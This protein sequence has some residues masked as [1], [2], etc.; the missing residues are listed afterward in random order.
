MKYRYN[1]DKSSK[2]Y[3]CPNCNKKT[4]VRYFDNEK[5]EY[6]PNEIGRC[7]RENKCGYHTAPKGNY[8]K[9]YEVKYTTPPPISYHSYTLVS[10]CGRNYK[11]NNFV[12]FLKNIFTI[13]EVKTVILKYLIG[14]SKFW[15]GATVFWQIDNNKNVRHGKVMLYN[16]KT[17]KRL[18]NASGNAFITSV[19]SLLKL[20]NFNLKQ[21]LFGLHLI[22]KK[23][24][25]TIGIVESEKTAVIMSLFKPNYV[26]LA[27]GS[28]HG[29]KYEM[30]KPII[31]YNIIAFPDKG[32]Y[33]DWQSKAMELNDYGFKIKVSRFIEDSNHVNGTDLAD[34]YLEQ[35][36]T[37]KKPKTVTTITNT[38]TNF[39]RVK[40][41][42]EAKIKRM[43]KKNV[44]LL[45][46]IDVFELTD[47][48][49]LPINVSSLKD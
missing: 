23:A 12:Q 11:H 48:N 22:N 45:K 19:R 28:K 8:I 4:F 15:D 32:E 16:I 20:N 6:L 3:H 13:D 36:R 49:N 35:I 42:T 29:F 26:W 24:S 21:C 44:N 5:K 14:T 33:N 39:S 7:D 27:T 46:L 25:Q 1:L 34:I 43:M 10:H 38:S 9:T 31:S 18:K 41:I 17:G 30:L 2:K 40:S 37:S 47:E